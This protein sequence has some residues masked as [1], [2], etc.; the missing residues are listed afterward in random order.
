MAK[1]IKTNN[2]FYVNHV[3][4]LMS[5]R[6][7]LISIIGKNIG[8]DYGWRKAILSDNFVFFLG[9]ANQNYTGSRITGSISNPKMLLIFL[10]VNTLFMMALISIK[11]GVL[12]V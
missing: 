2:D 11:M 3:A 4:D 12:L 10:S 6:K 1:R 9:T 8:L 5:G 7:K